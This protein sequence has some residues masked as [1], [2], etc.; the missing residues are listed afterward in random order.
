MRAAHAMS[1][2]EAKDLIN[3]RCRAHLT[4][5]RFKRLIEKVSL[6]LHSPIALTPAQAY[7][8]TIKHL[9]AKA[10]TDHLA[11]YGNNNHI[12]W[13]QFYTSAI[14]LST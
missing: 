9:P 14:S 12:E 5:E 13:V 10:F 3:A 1:L 6:H 8:D 2:R 4:I 7:D 11:S